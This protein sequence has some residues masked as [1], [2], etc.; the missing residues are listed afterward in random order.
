MTRVSKMQYGMTGN[1]KSFFN[2]ST[3]SGLSVELEPTLDELTRLTDKFAN[4][5]FTEY[6]IRIVRCNDRANRV[7][8]K[9]DDLEIYNVKCFTE[10]RQVN[11]HDY[12]FKFNN[13]DNEDWT[14]GN[15]EKPARKEVKTVDW[16]ELRDYVKK[17]SNNE[18]T[19]AVIIEPSPQ[20]LKAGG[21]IEYGDGKRGILV[22]DVQ[23]GDTI[24]DV[25]HSGF[26]DKLQL[27]A[28]TGELIRVP[29]KKIVDATRVEKKKRRFNFDE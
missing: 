7:Y 17:K 11:I 24:I 29:T 13:I 18:N 15:W 22:H 10:A 3:S 19:E 2:F 20:V 8:L 5:G 25:M 6:D 9:I 27:D 28:P 16:G 14:R 21:V 26:V 12:E 23:V 4:S 1:G